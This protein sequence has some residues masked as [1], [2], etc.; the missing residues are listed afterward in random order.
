MGIFVLVVPLLLLLSCM[1]GQ[2]VNGYPMVALVPDQTERCFKFNIPQDDEAHMILLPFPGP[3]EITDH[4]HIA[5]F[6]EQVF[7]MTKLK[8][9]R[10]IPPKFPD[11]APND[12]NEMMEKY[13]SE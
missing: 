2:V 6:Q 8:D 5:W 7:E 9:D 3:E 4:T 1:G 12:V 10:Q 11:K 13:I